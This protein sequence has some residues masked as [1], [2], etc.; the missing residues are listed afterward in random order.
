[1]EPGPSESGS[2]KQGLF[3][4]IQPDGTVIRSFRDYFGEDFELYVCSALDSYITLY[5]DPRDVEVML[6]RI[7]EGDFDLPEDTNKREI[8]FSQINDDNILDLVGMPV[9][10]DDDFGALDDEVCEY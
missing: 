5:D 3:E 10:L 9:H 6:S 7:D 4:E 2:V 8:P 1:M